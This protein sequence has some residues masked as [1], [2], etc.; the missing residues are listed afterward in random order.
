[1]TDR[2]IDPVARGRAVRCCARRPVEVD[3][4][5]R[6]RFSRTGTGRPATGVPRA[7]SSFLNCS[8]PTSRIDAARLAW[9]RREVELDGVR[10]R[11]GRVK[12]AAKQQVHGEARL[13]NLDHGPHRRLE[14][15][16]L[17]SVD[18]FEAPDHAADLRSRG[19]RVGRVLLVEDGPLGDADLLAG[20]SGSRRPRAGGP[21]PTRSLN[22]LPLSASAAGVG[23]GASATCGAAAGSRGMSRRYQAATAIETDDEGE[24]RPEQPRSPLPDRERTTG[25]RLSTRGRAGAG[26]SPRRPPR[27][28]RPRDRPRRVANTSAAGAGGRGAAAAGRSTSSSEDWPASANWAGVGGLARPGSYS[29]STRA[30]ASSRDDPLALDVRLRQAAGR[31]SEAARAAPCARA[32]RRWPRICG[33]LL[34]EAFDRRGRSADNSRPWALDCPCRS[35]RVNPQ[36]GCASGSCR[37]APGEVDSTATGAPISSSTRRTYLIACAGRSA[38]ERA[39]AVDPLQPSISS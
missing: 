32:R 6:N 1:M 37:R 33:R 11:Q 5:I 35:C 27:T 14:R 20:R 36:T 8:S 24:H 16:A 29:A 10:G 28:A 13:G 12:V 26:A 7:P 4:P 15:L 31:G 2:Q 25:A 19:L 17:A 30:I 3:S 39:P 23:F 9:P 34:G 22:L 18:A 21:P 38:H